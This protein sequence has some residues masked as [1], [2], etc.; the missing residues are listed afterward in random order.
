MK[1]VNCLQ[2]LK[3]QLVDLEIKILSSEGWFVN[4]KHGS[5]TMSFGDVYLNGALIKSFDDVSN[6]NKKSKKNIELEKSLKKAK[7]KKR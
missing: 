6:L 3:S 2:D 5:W 7:N 4:T 1:G